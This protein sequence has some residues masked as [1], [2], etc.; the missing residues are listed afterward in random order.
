M[1]HSSLAWVSCSCG[2]PADPHLPVLL[3]T[4]WIPVGPADVKGISENMSVSLW[5]SGM[6][7]SAPLL[8]LAKGLVL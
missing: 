5:L 3:E 8:A 4:L 1:L 7:L 2:P 6:G